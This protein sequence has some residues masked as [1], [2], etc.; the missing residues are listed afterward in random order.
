M[1]ITYYKKKRKHSDKKS[2]TKWAEQLHDENLNR[3]T[4]Y[5]L[6]FGQQKT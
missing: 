2:E 5:N 6:P 4:I 3:K 1:Y